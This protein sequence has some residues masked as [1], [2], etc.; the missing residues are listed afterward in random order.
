MSQRRTR[1]LVV[2]DSLTVRRYLVNLIKSSEYF[3]LAGE[4]EDGANAIEL[5]RGLRPDVISLDMML[6]RV[7]GLSV[8]EY[9][10]AHFPTP[11]LIVSASTNRGELFRTYDALTAGA[12][13]VLEK[14][15]DIFDAAWSQRYL[16]SLRR[17]SR[18][19][20]VTHIRG[21]SRAAGSPIPKESVRKQAPVKCI[22]IGASTGGP[23]AV[24]HI[25]QNLPAAFP[26]PILVVIHIGSPFGLAL[27]DWLDAQSPLRVKPASDGLD[28]TDGA[29][30]ILARDEYHMVVEK[31]VV[32]LSC[33]AERHSCRPSVDV[34][35][36]SVAA[37]FGPQAAAVLLTGMGRDGARG[38]L[39]V[40]KAGGFTIA[41]DEATSLIYGMPREAI[42]LGAARIVLPLDEIAPS[43]LALAKNGRW[44]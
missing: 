7:S 29:Q 26:L 25:L 13:D 28:F 23:G 19:K 27:A 42:E 21:K 41:Q 8:T 3:E 16:Q 1:V 32:R 4:A 15:G 6:P 22:A 10:M 34:L 36:E 11:I 14:P 43:L 40:K 24:L 31:Q 39:A 20:V 18:I 12:V 17:V 33:A 2:E 5:V 30:V 9:V 35:F 37:E 44:E 38:L